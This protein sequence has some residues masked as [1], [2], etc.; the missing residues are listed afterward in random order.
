VW[1]WDQMIDNLVM[2]TFLPNRINSERM[3]FIV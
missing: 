1:G 3:I 2:N